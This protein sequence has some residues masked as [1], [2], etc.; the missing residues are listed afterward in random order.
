[1]HSAT[2]CQ[3]QNEKTS[4]NSPEATAILLRIRELESNRLASKS[5]DRIRPSSLPST[6]LLVVFGVLKSAIG[7]VIRNEDV[8]TDDDSRDGRR[9]RWAP[10]DGASAGTLEMQGN[11]GLA[12]TQWPVPYFDAALKDCVVHLVIPHGTSGASSL[13]CRNDHLSLVWVVGE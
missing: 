12:L 7:I 4:A 10:L 3:W 9:V 11:D 1:L 5:P 2:P 13:G 6:P 8:V